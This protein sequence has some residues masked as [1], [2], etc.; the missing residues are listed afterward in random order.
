MT[1]TLSGAIGEFGKA[2]KAKLK[3]IAASGEPEDQLRAPFEALL[4]D[5]T[6]LVGQPRDAVVAVGES[7]VSDL[8]TRPDYAVTRRNVLVGFIELKAPRKG[9]DPRKYKNKHDKQQWAKLQSLPN[10][11]Y[12]DGNAFSLWRGDELVS[13]VQ[14][15]GDIETSGSQLDTPSELLKLFNDFLLWEP[16][17][18]RDAK[19]L[20][21]QSAQLCRFLRDEVTEQLAAGSEALTGLATGWRKMLFP[22]ATNEQFAD[23]YA[24]AVTFGLLVARAKNIRIGDGIDRV[25]KELGATNSLIGAAL[26]IM[27]QEV[28][29]ET[30][31]KTS[32][33]TLSRVLDVVQWEAISKGDPDVWLYFYEDFLEA[34]DNAL[35]KKTGSYYTPPEVVAAMIRLVDEAL[36]SPD[37]FGLSRG[38]ASNEVTVAD[39]AVG[40]GTFMLGMLRR[41]GETVRANEGE[42]AVPGAIN[43]ALDRLIAFEMQLGPFAVAQLRILAEVDALTNGT[44]TVAPRMFVTDTLGDPYIGNSPF[45]ERMRVLRA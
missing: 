19:Q 3:N 15:D 4:L 32:L 9:A 10:L 26:R 34:Y 45:H 23:G 24:Q 28:E 20:A 35:R 43:A 5:L 41:I 6:E 7:S 12:T 29:S 2:A 37:R 11:I 44:S 25:A 36:S 33:A 16:V 14:L 40:T 39:P 30:T 8:K 13:L 38:L 27:T 31:L 42:G 22:E 17:P 18:P 1:L 21:H